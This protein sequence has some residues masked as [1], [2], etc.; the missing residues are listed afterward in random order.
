MDFIPAIL[1]ILL[2]ILVGTFT[3]LIPGLHIN[4]VSIF[5]ITYFTSINPIYLAIFIFAMSITHT[6]LNAI[7]SVLLG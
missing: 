4:L 5:A 3:G 6:F 7:P 2:G 1:S